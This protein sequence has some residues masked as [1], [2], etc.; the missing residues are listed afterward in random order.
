MNTTNKIQ[1]LTLIELEQRIEF[2]CCGGGNDG[3]NDGDGP[4][5]I[6]PGGPG[7]C[8]GEICGGDEPTI[9]Q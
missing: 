6:P 3:G 2:G 4:P 5:Q 1:Q 8:G 9:P 7:P